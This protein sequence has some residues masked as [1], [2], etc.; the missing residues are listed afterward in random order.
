MKDPLAGEIMRKA[1]L[2][3]KGKGKGALEH[4]KKKAEYMQKTGDKDD[5]VFWQRIATQIELLIE[6]SKHG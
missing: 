3:M 5:Q 4:A 1:Q 6:E 2:L